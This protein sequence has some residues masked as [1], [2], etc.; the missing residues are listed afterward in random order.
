MS[1][2]LCVI[3]HMLFQRP[4]GERQGLFLMPAAIVQMMLGSGDVGE[5]WGWRACSAAQQR[6]KEQKLAEKACAAEA[7]AARGAAAQAAGEAGRR[8][9]EAARKAEVQAALTRSQQALEAR[10]E[11]ILV[12]VT[13]VCNTQSPW[14]AR[15]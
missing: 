15:S 12:R 9:R 13:S 6:E 2:C 3:P 11:D 1:W 4:A 14:T 10:T 7:S 8:A 5:W